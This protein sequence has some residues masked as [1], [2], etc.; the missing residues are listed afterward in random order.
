MYSFQEE[1]ENK[2]WTLRVFKP[3]DAL[4]LARNAD[5]PNIAATLRNHFPSPFTLAHAREWIDTVCEQRLATHFAI[6]WGD[7]VIGGIGFKQQEDIHSSSAEIGYWVA[8]PYWGQ[9]IATAALSL[10]RG[11]AFRH[12]DFLR[13]YSTVFSRNQASIRVL[14]K[15]GFRFEA[16]LR[17]HIVK[18]GQ[19]EDM[20]IFALLR[21]EWIGIAANDACTRGAP[22]PHEI[23]GET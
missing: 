3:D 18:Q 1:L 23:S 14:E 8:E 11:Y 17:K 7:E 4:S 19:V 2:S 16:R 22:P 20:L 15:A 5:N 21:E 13:L 10:V 9:G 6:A 12:F